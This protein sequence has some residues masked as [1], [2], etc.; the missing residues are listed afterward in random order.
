MLPHG[1]APAPGHAAE[2]YGGR[3]ILERLAHLCD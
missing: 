2:T 3:R 1:A